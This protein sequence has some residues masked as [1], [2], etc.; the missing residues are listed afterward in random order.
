MICR[1]LHQQEENLVEAKND[2]KSS[3]D[4]GTLMPQVPGEDITDELSISGHLM[5]RVAPLSLPCQ[6]QN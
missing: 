6:N 1:G 2:E 3:P 4:S 5:E